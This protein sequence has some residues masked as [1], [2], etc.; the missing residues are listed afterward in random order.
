MAHGSGASFY[1]TPPPIHSPSPGRSNA[2]IN[3]EGI[4]FMLSKFC[5]EAGLNLSSVAMGHERELHVTCASAR[6]TDDLFLMCLLSQGITTTCVGGAQFHV[7]TELKQCVRCFRRKSAYDSL[8]KHLSFPV[9]ARG[10]LTSC[11]CHGQS[12]Q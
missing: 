6:R 8:E 10:P 2:K 12:W 7:D 11:T 4:L 5:G 9:R 3:Y 1:S